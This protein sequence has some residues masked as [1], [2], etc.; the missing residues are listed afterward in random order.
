MAPPITAHNAMNA[1]RPYH[2]DGCRYGTRISLQRS[3]SKTLQASSSKM[4]APCRAARSIFN[5]GTDLGYDPVIWDQIFRAVHASNVRGAKPDTSPPHD[6]LR[7]AVS[8][9]DL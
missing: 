1:S 7:S 2:R 4:P 5:S 9:K 3:A 8:F 6:I